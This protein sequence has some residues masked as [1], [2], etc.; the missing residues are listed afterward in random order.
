MSDPSLEEESL[1]SQDDIDKLLDSPSIGEDEE[2]LENGNDTGPDLDDS[3]ELSQ[4]DIDS[5]LTGSSFDADIEESLE[6]PLDDEM[7][8]LSQDDIDSL[9]GGNDPVEE[10]AET[11]MDEM[12]ELSQDDIDG[13]M[14]GN[15]PAAEAAET[16]ADEMGELSQDDIDSLMGGNDLAAE[17][18]E[19]EADEMGEL[20]QD[21]IDGLMGG[22]DLA[23]DGDDVDMELIS[24]NDIDQLMTPSDEEPGPNEP[25]NTETNSDDFVID[26][27]DGLDVSACL[28]TQETFDE[29]IGNLPE[30]EDV[31]DPVVLESD[32]VAL[33][34]D[35]E[36]EPVPLADS[37]EADL[38]VDASADEL[39]DLLNNDIDDTDINLG[40]PDGDDVTQ[41]DIDALLQASDEDED[42]MADEDDILISQDD[43]DT[44]LMAADQEDEDLLG[45][46]MGDDMSA[47]MDDDFD[48]QDI[49]EDDDEDDALSGGDQVVL[50]GGEDEELDEEGGSGKPWKNWAKSRLVIATA[51]AI[52]VLGISVPIVYFLFFSQAPV[53]I[54]EKMS[55]PIVMEAPGRDIQVASVDINVAA[56]VDFKTSG[57]IVLADFVVLASDMSK[58][59]AYVTA[60]ISID[61]SDQRAY[62]EIKDNLS[63]YRDLIYESIQKNLLGE[64]GNEVT[65]ADLIWGIE[66]SLKKVFPLDYIDKV[67]F[68][69]FKA[70]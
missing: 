4:D 43:I 1:I 69:S 56:A 53:E 21:D 16:E 9:M 38:E 40:S 67:S 6:A 62:H 25:G 58:D 49:L 54:P 70:S 36:P 33:D 64:R 41:D 8:E 42:F 11:E 37:G 52:L 63:F 44:L 66:T 61:Y 24:Q 50:E 12:G 15:D 57:N 68:K 10:A 28:I 65:E 3:G 35:I 26:E 14:G 29:L 23:A 27:A 31:P 39:G 55:V 46:L 22:N 60:D 17:T 19:T 47:G 5:L 48:D 7:G 13:L 2:T 45:D 59:M 20:S 32:P 34:E 18:A 30:P 51:S